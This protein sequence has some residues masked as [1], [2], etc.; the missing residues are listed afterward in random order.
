MRTAAA[1]GR[2][3]IRHAERHGSSSP[4][5]IEGRAGRPLAKPVHSLS[6]GLTGDFAAGYRHRQDRNLILAPDPHHG[7]HGAAGF[8][9]QD[10]DGGQRH[11]AGAKQLA[12]CGGDQP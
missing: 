6:G 10:R 4:L 1:S 3:A 2:G 9:Q 12:I 11:P 5:S 7:S 8:T